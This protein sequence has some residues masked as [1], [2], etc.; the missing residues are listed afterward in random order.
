MGFFNT[1][2]TV[3]ISSC[4]EVSDF[5]L[6]F[7]SLLPVSGELTQLS[8]LIGGNNVTVS[9]INTPGSSADKQVLIDVNLS[10]Y[11]TISYI[12]NNFYTKSNTYTKT[13]INNSL[14]TKQATISG[15][16]TTILTSDLSTNLVLISNASGKV[17][18]S[19]ISDTKLG[20]L[21]D[22]TSNIQAQ[23]NGKQ[24]TMSGV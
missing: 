23:L 15:A 6:L 18:V 3:T 7:I 14:N 5:I 11:Y 8:K 22:V 1:G 2:F 21:T 20:Y 9:R 16:A 4:A 24:A 17:A 10:N 19:N 13:E 12:D